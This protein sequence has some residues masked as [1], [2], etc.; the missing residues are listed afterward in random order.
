MVIVIDKSNCKFGSI[1]YILKNNSCETFFIYKCYVQTS[2][3]LF[4]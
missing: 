4:I 2:K 3:V 1:Q